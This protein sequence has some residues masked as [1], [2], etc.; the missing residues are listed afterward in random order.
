MDFFQW[1]NLLWA[2]NGANCFF[3]SVTTGVCVCVFAF[4]IIIL[5]CFLLKA[6]CFFGGMASY[7]EPCSFQRYGRSAPIFQP[8]SKDNLSCENRLLFRI[9][10]KQNFCSYKFEAIF[11]RTCGQFLY[12]SLSLDCTVKSMARISTWIS[13]DKFPSTFFNLSSFSS[14]CFLLQ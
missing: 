4:Y 12:Y 11:Q 10:W 14:E 1:Q 6:V 5:F 2:N 13:F 3:Q 9:G 8:S 7:C